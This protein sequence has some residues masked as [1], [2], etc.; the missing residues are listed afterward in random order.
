[1]NSEIEIEY[2]K[3]FDDYSEKSSDSINEILV[4]EN[5][6][7]HIS[8]LYESLNEFVINMRQI[9]MYQEH[10]KRQIDG[11]DRFSSVDFAAIPRIFNLNYD[12]FFKTYPKLLA[13]ISKSYKMYNMVEFEQ[14]LLQHKNYLSKPCKTPFNSG[15]ESN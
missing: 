14:L 3:E 8:N 4:N 10:L 5:S 6:F 12:L 7:H 13:A 11:E 2:T 9:C 1:M 15:E